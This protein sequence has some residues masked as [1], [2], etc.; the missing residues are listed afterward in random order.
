MLLKLVNTFKNVL[1]ATKRTLKSLLVSSYKYIVSFIRFLGSCLVVFGRAVKGYVSSVSRFFKEAKQ[2]GVKTAFHS[3]IVSLKQMKASH[4]P[5]L[6]K[7]AVVAVPLAFM[8]LV[9]ITSPVWANF[10]FAKRVVYAKTVLGEVLDATIC[11]TAED[12]FVKSLD[13]ANGEAY[14]EEYS[15]NTVYV[16]KKNVLSAETLAVQ[17]LNNTEGLVNGYGL[18]VNDKLTLVSE[19]SEP[20]Y[21]NLTLTLNKYKLGNQTAKTEFVERV[22]VRDGYF[23]VE[24]C[25]NLVAINDAFLNDEIPLSVKTYAVE[26]YDVSVPYTTKEIRS[27]ALTIGKTQLVKKGQNG[28]NHVTANVIYVNGVELHREVT[29][30]KVVTKPVTRQI[31]VGTKKGAPVKSSKVMMWPIPKSTD[32]RISSEFNNDRG[33]HYHKGVDIACDKGTPIYAVMSGTVTLSKSGGSYG[34]HIMIDHGNGIVTLYAHCS[35]LYV[36][37]GDKVAK[38]EQIAAVGNTGRSTGNHL[39]IEVRVNG[40]HNNPMKYLDK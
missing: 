2:G 39:H 15:L 18:Y 8:V 37:V 5:L 38:G 3:H 24:D 14:I 32:Y 25:K 30:T 34:K 40:K 20:F 26:E 27:N 17:M 13:C 35:A 12:Y 11:K 19:T 33:D 22:E 9:G 36:S 4:K 28:K 1:K 10:T 29:D 31:V 7:F 6:S 16:M 23:P 21:T